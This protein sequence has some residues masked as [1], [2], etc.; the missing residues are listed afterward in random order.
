[1]Q[2]DSRTQLPFSR[3]IAQSDIAVGK[4]AP[5]AFVIP[6]RIA[7]VRERGQLLNFGYYISVRPACSFG[8][9]VSDQLV[10]P[11]LRGHMES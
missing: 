7:F 9:Q 11:F 4:I 8:N 2:A 10:R 3:Y 6:N 1:M 5:V